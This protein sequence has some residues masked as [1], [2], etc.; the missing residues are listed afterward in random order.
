MH[1]LASSDIATGTRMDEEGLFVLQSHI[2]LTVEEAY[3]K[4]ACAPD[5]KCI[6]SFLVILVPES[7]EIRLLGQ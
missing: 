2:S 1:S 6:F 5:H 3:P 7:G 4:S